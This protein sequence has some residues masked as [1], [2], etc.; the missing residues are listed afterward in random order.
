MRPAPRPPHLL[1][2][3]ATSCRPALHTCP[4]REGRAHSPAFGRA[5]LQPRPAPTTPLRQNRGGTRPGPDRTNAGFPWAAFRRPAT[6]GHRLAG[7]RR[8]VLRPR[9]RL[10][11]RAASA[12]QP[13]CAS[14]R[15]SSRQALRCVIGPERRPRLGDAAQNGVHQPRGARG[16]CA[17]GLG[18]RDRGVHHAMSLFAGDQGARPPPAAG[19]CAPCWRRLAFDEGCDDRGRAVPCVCRTVCTSRAARAASAGSR[20]GSGLRWVSMRLCITTWVSAF[21]AA[22]RGAMLRSVAMDSFR[23]APA[24]PLRRLLRWSC[25]MKRAAYITGERQTTR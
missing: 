14:A 4:A 23:F 2:P 7:S 18:Q 20:P 15:R 24:C 10:R 12:R 16:L 22:R 11:W 1:Q 21:S 5:G 9:G 17:A 13:I 19:S 25:A 6:P 3:I 8:A